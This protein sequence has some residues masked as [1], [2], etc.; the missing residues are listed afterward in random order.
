MKIKEKNKFDCDLCHSNLFNKENDIKNK[1]GMNTNQYD[2]V[3]CQRCGLTTLFPHPTLKEISDFYI[4]Y[5]NKKDRLKVESMRQEFIYPEKLKK[6]E[7][8][9]QVSACSILEPEWADLRF[10]QSNEVLM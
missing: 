4:D 9:R 7:K 1:I 3:K 8:Y 10:W 2:I 5:G 6:L